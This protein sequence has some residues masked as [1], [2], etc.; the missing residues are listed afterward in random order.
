MR[1]VQANIFVSF[2]FSAI[3][4]CAHTVMKAYDSPS[5]SMNRV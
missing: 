1:K 5:A 4:L 2:K 3:L